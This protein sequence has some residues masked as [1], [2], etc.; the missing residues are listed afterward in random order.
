MTLKLTQ[1]LLERK[2]TGKKAD[3]VDIAR[4]VSQTMSINNG[5]TE[6]SEKQTRLNT[7]VDGGRRSEQMALS[8][9]EETEA[10]KR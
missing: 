3:I 9:D 6:K 1:K 8:E 7:E 4:K 2:R 5:L 10:Q